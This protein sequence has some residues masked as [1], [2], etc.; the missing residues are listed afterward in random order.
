VG[1]FQFDL[2]PDLRDFSP[3]ELCPVPGLTIAGRQ[4]YLYSAW[5]PQSVV[6]THFRWM[7]QYGIDGALLQRFVVDMNS[8]RKAGDAVV[9][10]VRA[11]A[12]SSG[13]AFAIEYDVSGAN[14]ATVLRDLQNDWV[15]L[16]HD[17][18]LP[19]S[20]SYLH[21]NGRPV[22][23]IWGLAFHDQKHVYDP[24]LGR[25]IVDWFKRTANV[26]VIGGLSTSWRSLSGVNSADPKWKDVY[27]MLDGIEP[28]AT[29]TL[30][31]R[32]AVEKWGHEKLAPE[33]SDTESRGQIYL[34]VIS[35]GFSWH[36][37]QN[38]H[39]PLNRTPRNNGQLYWNEA[40]QVQAAGATCLKVAMFD[41]VNEG[42][43]IYKVAANRADAPD[44]GEWLTLDAEGKHL[45]SDYYLRLTYEISKAFHAH[46]PIPEA[47]PQ[48]PGP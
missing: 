29:G 10:N 5:A 39:S 28:W 35:P 45:P 7:Q 17:L 16:S 11:G 42:T 1:N 44:Q 14:A 37:L 15:Y 36:N 30:Q 43:A 34:P 48:N 4:A 21:Q 25:Q 23:F 33:I 12:E 24:A 27:A 22:V 6:L 32:A 2:Y 13:R 46:T 9:K 8:I 41:E 38:G 19:N 47:I 31:D 40:R 18:N 26:T 20:K 3:D